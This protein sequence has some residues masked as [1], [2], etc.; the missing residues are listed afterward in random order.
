M[1][2]R[3]PSKAGAGAGFDSLATLVAWLPLVSAS[4]AVFA[5]GFFAAADFFAAGFFFAALPRPRLPRFLGLP[6][7]T[8]F[9][10]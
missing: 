3:E 10:A 9:V 7:G 8:I 2:R 4:A 6:A 1:D 5:V